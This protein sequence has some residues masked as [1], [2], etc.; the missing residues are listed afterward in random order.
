MNLKII[1]KT[2]IK[3]ERTDLRHAV[4]NLQ[5]NST[6]AAKSSLNQHSL[7]LCGW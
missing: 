3:K 6:S 5:K 2:D 4:S 1:F 7:H